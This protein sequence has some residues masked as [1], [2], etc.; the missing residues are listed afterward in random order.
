[1]K[2]AKN[3]ENCYWF[4]FHGEHL[5]LKKQSEKGGYTIPYGIEPPVSKTTD[6]YLHT[7]TPLND[8]PCKAFSIQEEYPEDAQY[9]MW[10]LRASWDV[11][12]EPLYLK[13]GKAREIL[14]W[15]AQHLYCG[16]CGGK[17][18]MDTEISKKC[19]HCGMKIWPQLSTAIIVL[20]HHEDKILLVHAH[21]LRGKFYGLV[22]GFVE[23]GE[24][25]EQAVHREVMEE[26][27]LTIKNLKYFSSQPWP[28]PCGL[29]VGFTAEYESGVIHL[30][31]SELSAGSWF[32]KSTLPEI[33]R[34]LSIARQLINLW[35]DNR[36]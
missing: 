15:D 6:A 27:G 5:L 9:K 8:I 18:V 21:N 3:Q 17:M 2:E 25:L 13:A 31:E 29:M 23:T 26:T 1:M 10:D 35:L 36:I 20:V 22:A 34:N 30:Q 7:L 19:T 4:V 16:K 32:T 14:Y 24:T 28:Y 12:K 33:P 11:L